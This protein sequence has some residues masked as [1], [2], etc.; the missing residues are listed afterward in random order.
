M[1]PPQAIADLVER[2]GFHRDAYLQGRKNETELRRSF[3][4]PFFRALGWDVDNSAGYSEA[5]KAVAH[6]DPIRI[7]GQTKFIDY[8]FRIGGQR[9]FL[10]EAKKPSVSIRDDPA[11]ALQIRRYAWSAGLPLSILTDFE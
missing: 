7:G 4:D 8:A 2:F 5:Y 10:A 11:P 3:L 6:E 1:T 9:R